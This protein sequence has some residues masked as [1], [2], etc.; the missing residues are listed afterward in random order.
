MLVLAKIDWQAVAAVIGGIGLVVSLVVASLALWTAK[1]AKAQAK[2]AQAQADA[3][4]KQTEIAEREHMRA[5]EPRLRVGRESDGSA[6]ISD[7][8]PKIWVMDGPPPPPS[9]RLRIEIENL[10][11]AAADIDEVRINDYPAE[12]Q[13]AGCE[14]GKPAKADFAASLFTADREP[15]EILV[16][17]HA[18][19]SGHLGVMEATV[20]RREGDLVV[21]GEK[22]EAV[23]QYPLR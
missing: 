17:Y 15:H 12:P 23:E 3:A 8:V 14:K 9:D 4:A 7:P 22:D 21:L 5:T 11:D 18:R 2:A 19:D 1:S 20:E 10:R 6:R 13:E 16:L